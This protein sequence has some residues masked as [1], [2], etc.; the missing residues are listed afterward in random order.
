ML[1]DLLNKIFEP[2]FTTKELEKGHRSGS[3]DRPGY[4]QKP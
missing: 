4:R 3:F 1:R 2:F